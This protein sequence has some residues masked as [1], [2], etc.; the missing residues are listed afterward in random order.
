MSKRDEILGHAV[1]LASVE[2][3]GGLTI[4]RLAT[5]LK[6][7]KSGL[8]GHFGSKE[9]LQLAVVKQ[10]GRIFGERVLVPAEKA[11]AGL[12]RA[13]AIADGWLDY[14]AGGFEGGCFFHAASLEFDGRPGAVRDE[15]ARLT[16]RWYVML[17]EQLRRAAARRQLLASA[18][19][20]LLTFEIHALLGEANWAFQLFGRRE[21]IERARTLVHA[22]LARANDAGER[23]SA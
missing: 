16:G 14:L 7:S 13:T 10:A 9:E 3:L 22:K 19:V 8:F 21:A 20:P 2:G 18:D 17:E 12:D 5:E 23:R 6:M 11:E 4:G 1:A 15:V